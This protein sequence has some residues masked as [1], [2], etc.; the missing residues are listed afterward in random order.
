MGLQVKDLAGLSQP[1]TKAIE[2][3]SAGM[4]TV[5][6]PLGIKREAD[7]KAYEIETIARA[8]AQAE[9]ARKDVA[10]AGILGRL[11]QIQQSDPDFCQRARQ[12]LLQRELEGQL[13]VE[14]IAG[15]AIKLLPDQVSNEPVSPD[16]RRKFFMEADNVCSADLQLLWG[17]VLAGEIT[18]PGSFSLRTLEV[19]KN[20]SQDEAQTF[21]KLCTLA[22]A[23]GWVVRPGH[24]VNTT[25][26]PFGFSYGQLLVLR[27]AGLL[28]SGDTLARLFT[29]VPK[30]GV[31]MQNNGVLIQMRTDA[32]AEQKRSV[33]SLPF[34]QAGRELQRLIL[35][36]P[37]EEYL[38]T[39]GAFL[40][41]L[42]I[43]V[44]RGVVISQDGQ[45]STIGFETDL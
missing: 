9:E 15:Q 18:T 1:L 2:V 12:R 17:K 25:L 16:W 27:D 4:G 23:E 30:Q 38:K 3:I 28:H 5:Y 14:A 10:T 37:N 6:R 34:S 40:R 21:S 26:D 33:P 36:N 11:Q 39:M 41:T 13:N 31:V 19:L 20:L 8:E 45:N 7:A 22:M 24:D 44:K 32:E 42:G 29:F 35:P 43:V